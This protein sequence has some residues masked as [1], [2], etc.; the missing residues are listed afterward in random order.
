MLLRRTLR[1]KKDISFLG[2]WKASEGYDCVGSE[3]AGQRRKETLLLSVR[4]SACNW[5]ADGDRRAASI[6]C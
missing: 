5:R 6:I 3:A 2:R 1:K 4:S